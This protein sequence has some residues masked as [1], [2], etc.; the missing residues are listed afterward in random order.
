MKFPFWPRSRRDEDLRQELEGH[1]Q[2]AMDDRTERG[3]NPVQAREGARREFGNVDLVRGVT[4]AQWGWDWVE[5]L[6]QDIRY[7]ARMLRKNPG[8]TSVAILTLALGIG[9]NTAIFSLVDAF[10]LKLLPVK[11]P[12]QLVV[13]K[14]T[15]PEGG[16]ENDFPLS[17]FEQFRDRSRSFSGIFARDNSRVSITVNG[18]PELVWGDFV[19]GSFFDVLGIHAMLGRTFTPDDDQGGMKPVALI[20]HDFWVRRFG[21]DPSVIGKTIYLGKIPFTV[22]G[23]T[24]QKFHGLD[25]MDQGLDMILPMFIQPRLALKDHDTFEVIGR[26]KPGVK[27]DGARAELDVIYQQTLRQSAGSSISAETSRQIRARRIELKPGLRGTAN[28]NDSLARE[29]RVLMAIVGIVLVIACVNVA[30]LLLARGAMRRKEI[31]VRLAIG[32][33]RGR[34]IRQF[35]T[36]S[37]LLSALGGVLGLLMA[38][39]AVRGLLAVLLYGGDSVPFE[40]TPDPG[41]LAFTAGVSM[42]TGIFF[43]LA[44]ALTATRVDVNPALKGTN[45]AVNSRPIHRIVT[46]SLVVT[47]VALSLALLMG[48]G[49]LIRSIHQLYAVD[50]GYERN[51]VLMM[52]AFPALIGYD[53]GKELTLYKELQEKVNAIPGVESASVSRFRMVFGQWFRGVW[54]SGQ[55]AS[56]DATSQVYCNPVGPRFFQT[57]GIPLLLG[58]EFNASDTETSSRVAVISESMSRKFFPNENPLGHRIGF[59]GPQSGAQIQIVGVVKDIK[60]H[61]TDDQVHEGVFIP[62]TQAPAEILGQMNLVV[63]TAGPP[64][65]VIPEIGRRVQSV[66]PDLP[67]T[68]IE[69]EAAE[70]DNYLG[71]KRSLAALLSLFAVLAVGL[72]SIGLYGTMSHAVAERTKELGIRIALGALPGDMLWL[73]LRETL[74]LV[75]LGFGIGIPV[76]LAA[77]RLISTMLF[78]VKAADPVNMILCVLVM[79]V[80]ALGSGYVPARRAANVDPIVALRYE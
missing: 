28:P 49:L 4:R 42:L 17:T 62:Y 39:W 80:I 8:F 66:E 41:I 13:V 51:D 24:P 54:V 43:G 73:V 79:F 60:H 46:K 53:H 37:V 14:R 71:D 27:P 23:V 25:R 57:M 35:L 77:S 52:W 69:T 56:L 30:N 38:N 7:G 5:S 15:D 76:A 44:P 47:Q 67:L 6:L 55:A 64:S 33:S 61:L 20:T 68:D 74:A 63:R 9:A 59:D 32:A 36:E 72:A 1:L 70:V 3:E 2:M 29:L 10:L 48:A 45:G 19:S 75:S 22:I 40:F 11:D 21:R 78:G 65:G 18:H 12:K 50:T 16:I 31:A 34:L 58:R 26:L